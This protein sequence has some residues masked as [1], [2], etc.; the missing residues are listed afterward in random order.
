MVPLIL[1]VS[2]CTNLQVS[3]SPDLEKIARLVEQQQFG[4]ALAMI[5]RVEESAPDFA[6]WET[7]RKSVGKKAT[8]YRKN[9]IREGKE[10][11]R[12]GEWYQALKHYQ[13]ALNNLYENRR[14]QAAHD[15]LQRETGA[16]I[17]ALEVELLIAKG[18]WLK[19][20]LI[21][22][23]K[24]F[25]LLSEK[26]FKVVRHEVVREEAIQVSVALGVVGKRAVRQ[27]EYT[28]AEETL[29]LSLDLHPDPSIEATRKALTSEKQRV[30]VKKAQSAQ[31][32]LSVSLQEALNQRQLGEASDIAI[33]LKKRGTP[34]KEEQQLIQQLN[35]DIRKQVEEDL[36]LGADH[37]SRG[38][39]TEAVA[40]WNKVL[41]LEPDN[42]EAAIRNERAKRILEKLRQLSEE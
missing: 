10:L 7:L 36:D 30:I 42:T 26:Q 2:G 33:Q 12:Q 1:L 9:V 18:Q 16:S 29:D 3:R 37:Y 15:K 35:R 28:L 14:I 39:Y 41:A 21:V 25:P 6:E 24:L 40:A 22:Q 19:Q 31:R 17:D 11:E 34:S 13:Q 5:P 8:A 4:E 38:E 23:T 32:A 20:Q 27:G